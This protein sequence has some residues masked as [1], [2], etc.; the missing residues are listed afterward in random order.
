[1]ELKST[2]DGMTKFENVPFS[3]LVK[4]DRDLAA[5]RRKGVKSLIES[6]D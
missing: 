5:L 1:M 3:V 2:D 6:A 4:D